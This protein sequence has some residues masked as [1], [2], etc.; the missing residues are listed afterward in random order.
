MPVL[1]YAGQK[2]DHCKSIL[3]F[4]QSQPVLLSLVKLHNINT[5]G[6]PKGITRVPTLI[7]D[8]GKVLVGGEVRSCLEEMIPFEVEY[9]TL[10]SKLALDTDMFTLDMYGS[11]LAPPMTPALEEKIAQSVQDAYQ[12]IKK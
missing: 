10:G 7:T 8:E 4:M 3:E 2:C 12:N 6:V 11:S 9:T 1:V 5:H